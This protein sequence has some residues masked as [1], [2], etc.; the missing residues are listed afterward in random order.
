MDRELTIE[1]VEKI[2][3][4]EK[5]YNGIIQDSYIENSNIKDYYNYNKD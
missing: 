2:E 1:E 3:K 5:Y 4:I